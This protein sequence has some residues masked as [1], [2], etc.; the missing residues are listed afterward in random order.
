LAYLQGE[1]VIIVIWYSHCTK[2]RILYD[3]KNRKK[4]LAEGDKKISMKS[5]RKI[6]NLK[7]QTPMK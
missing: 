4:V 7:K 2:Q 3:M 5:F 6:I 1:F